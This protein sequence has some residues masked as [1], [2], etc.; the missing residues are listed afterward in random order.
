MKTS[1]VEIKKGN[2]GTG[3]LLENDG[4]AS[5][6]MPENKTLKESIEDFKSGAVH[7]L[8]H[9][10]ILSAVFQK[11][12][13]ENANGRIYPETILKREV[14]K[15]QEAINE[16]RAYGE[17]YTPDVLCLTD[18]GWKELSN[19]KEG[20]KVLSLNTETKEIEI[21]TVINKVHKEHDG[22]MIRIKGRNINDLVTPGHKFPIY[23]RYDKFDKFYTAQ[24]MFE[25]NI[26]D[27]NHKKLHSNGI[28]KFESQ[29][30]FTIPGI[31]NPNRVTLRNHPNCQEDLTL[32]LPVFMKFIGIY[33]S[34]GDCSKD[35][36][37]VRIHQKKEEVCTEIEDMLNELGLPFNIYIRKTD[38]KKVFNICDPRLKA[39]LE[40]LGNCYTKYIPIEL[41]KQSQENLRKLYDWFVLG[42]GRK[43][44][45]SKNLTDDVFS[46]SKRLI[47]DL[48]E[49]QLKIGYHGTYH[50]EQRDNDRYIDGR[51]IKGKNTQPLHFS[52]RSLNSNI[53]LDSRNLSITDEEYHGIVECI[54]LDKN[55]TWYVMSNGKCHWTGNCNHPDSSAIDAE[56]ICMNIVELHW[57]NK[58]LVGKIELPITEGFRKYGICSNL[59]DTVAQWII[60]GLKIGVSSRALGSVTQQ[61][62]H[63][64]VGDDLELVCW[65][66]VTQPSTPGAWI[67]SNDETLKPYIEEK[68]NSE[69]CLIKEDKFSKFDNW[70]NG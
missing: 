54:E 23:D 8:P 36:N 22:K 70:L 26:S 21:A 62:G 45:R 1:L 49:I 48:N 27:Y 33:L 61:M 53:A 66:V 69:G 56:R 63:L 55:H 65:D 40:P 28:W 14:E 16:H 51:L 18:E 9:P 7:N 64:I 38:G 2:I 20:D 52:L 6:D 5:L 31:K 10:F 50:I 68:K 59:A 44:G 34:E 17:C 4:Y 37:S 3:L 41:K 58:T 60:S 29:E 24:D 39:Y 30:S 12:G 35:N 32:S 43:R 13:V 15:Y 46:T 67:G 42:D 19:V 57:V 11:Y 25:K 47:L